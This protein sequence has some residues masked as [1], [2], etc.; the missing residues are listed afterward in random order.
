MEN[1]KG[2]L[3]D[4]YVLPELEAPSIQSLKYPSK[5]TN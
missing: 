3:V 1:D 4:L 5:S 2:E